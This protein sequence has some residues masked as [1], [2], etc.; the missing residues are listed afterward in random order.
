M[1]KHQAGRAWHGDIA[2]DFRTNLLLP[3]FP[4]EPTSLL[5]ESDTCMLPHPP[6]PAINVCSWTSGLKYTP[7][8]SK[9]KPKGIQDFLGG[10]GCGANMIQIGQDSKG[11]LKSS[12]KRLCLWTDLGGHPYRHKGLSLVFSEL[13]SHGL[14]WVSNPEETEK[15]AALEEAWPEVCQQTQPWQECL[16]PAPHSWK[17]PQ[18]QS[19]HLEAIGWGCSKGHLIIMKNQ[20]IF[21]LNFQCN[22]TGEPKT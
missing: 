4:L 15:G 14:A 6:S 20:G 8:L 22:F 7:E 3:V 5:V 12:T 17:P 21:I 11:H 19:Q 1:F 10:S 2:A 13:F 16:S 18:F 9:H